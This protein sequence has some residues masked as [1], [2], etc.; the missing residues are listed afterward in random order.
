MQKVRTKWYT[1]DIVSN[2]FKYIFLQMQ[3]E[4]I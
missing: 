3:M 4:K 1:E 2:N